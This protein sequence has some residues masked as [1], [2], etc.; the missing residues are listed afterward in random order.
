MQ[1]IVSYALLQH[2]EFC[3]IISQYTEYAEFC[4]EHAK[5]CMDHA[6]CCTEHAECFTEHAECCTD[7]AERCHINLRTYSAGNSQLLGQI[8]VG[9]VCIQ[10]DRPTRLP[11][12]G[13]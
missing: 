2:A 1:N 3:E 11:A 8:D 12:A 4:T 9:T 5:C 10:F 6:E 13:T 7:H